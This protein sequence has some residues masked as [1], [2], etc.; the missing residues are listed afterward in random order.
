MAWGH[1]LKRLT[2]KERELC[3]TRG[4]GCASCD[5]PVDYVSSYSYASGH[6]HAAHAR[7]PMCGDHARVFA[8]RF[9]LAWPTQDRKVKVRLLR[10]A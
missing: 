5:D 2:K 8:M 4:W 10:A 1:R 3:R 6:G 9:G 7:R